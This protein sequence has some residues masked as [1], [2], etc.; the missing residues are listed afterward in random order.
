MSPRDFIRACHFPK[1]EIYIYSRRFIYV[2]FRARV[3][4]IYIYLYECLRR[5][6]QP[7][8][9]LAPCVIFSS[10]FFPVPLSP[11]FFIHTTRHCRNEL[12]GFSNETSDR[13]RRVS[14]DNFSFSSLFLSFYPNE[15]N[16]HVRT[17]RNA[18]ADAS[19][20]RKIVYFRRYAPSESPKWKIFICCL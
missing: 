13:Y 12:Y 3:G 9:R 18:A 10:P 11:F 6:F 17:L 2:T 1:S 4:Q 5:G 20:L 16:T 14:R 19:M 8:F 7:I 15:R